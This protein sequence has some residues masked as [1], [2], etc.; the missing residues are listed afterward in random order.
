[1][2]TSSN[3]QQSTTLPLW[4]DIFTPWKRTVIL[5][6]VQ[7]CSFCETWLHENCIFHPNSAL[8]VDV[9]NIQKILKTYR[10]KNEVT[11]SLMVKEDIHNFDYNF[12]YYSYTTLH[13]MT[14][15]ASFTTAT[16]K[17]ATLHTFKIFIIVNKHRSICDFRLPLLSLLKLALFPAIT[18]WVEVNSLLTFW[19]NLSVSS[20]KVKNP[21]D[22]WSSYP[23]MLVKN[24][25]YS[26]CNSPEQNSSQINTFY[27]GTECYAAKPPTRIFHTQ[28]IIPIAIYIC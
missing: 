22:L 16:D 4:D 1:M 26:M 25:H 9:T 8:D 14:Y 18:Q 5:P 2:L 7:H 19:D 23:K 24:Y 11:R 27:K 12:I 21:L 10:N 15:K 28:D 13:F 20:S 3:Y 17:E 6:I